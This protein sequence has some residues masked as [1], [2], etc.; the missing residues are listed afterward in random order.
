[1][2]RRRDAVAQR[3]LESAHRDLEQAIELLNA[4]LD[5][6]PPARLEHSRT[7][8]GYAQARLAVRTDP[9][10]AG[11]LQARKG[12]ARLAKELLDAQRSLGRQSARWHQRVSKLRSAALKLESQ[13]SELAEQ[14][15]L[16]AVEPPPDRP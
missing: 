14:R 12:L 9:K 11:V 15:R 1:M 7:H 10:R 13:L 16:K 8:V 3:E 5:A 2:N 6:P 4:E